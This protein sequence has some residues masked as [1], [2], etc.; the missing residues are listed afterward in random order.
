MRTISIHSSRGG[1]GKTVIAT[2]L[3]AILAHNGFKV[4]LLD[5]DFRA[6][7]LCFIF[8][9]DLF[10]PVQHWLNDF[11]NDDCDAKQALIEVSGSLNANGGKLFVGLA[12]SSIEVIRNTI[13]KS[14]DAEVTAIKKLFSLLSIL[15]DDGIDYCIIDTSPG[16]QYSSVNALA[17][18][19]LCFLITSADMV[20]M[21]GCSE[22]LKDIYE[23]LEKKTFII[24]NKYSPSINNNSCT[25]IEFIETTLKHPVICQIPCYCEVLLAHRMGLLA[26]QQP[27]HPF[28]QKLEE[29]VNSIDTL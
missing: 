3:A 2:N 11:L 6:P 15:R 19:N 27:N 21:H 10:H 18:S 20:D 23:S 22:M 16:V 1:T 25:H 9:G 12:D 17:A 13:D 29:V 4:A 26:I 14:R 5:F 28:V 7:S 8:S 24:L